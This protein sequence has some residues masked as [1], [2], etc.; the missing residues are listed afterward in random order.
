MGKTMNILQLISKNT[1]IY[2][3]SW[4]V[5]AIQELSTPDDVRSAE[6]SQGEYGLSLKVYLKAGGFFYL[7]VSTHSSISKSTPVNWDTFDLLFLQKGDEYI[8]RI[9]LRGEASL[10]EE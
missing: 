7:E 2:K 5:Y 4:K 6:W 9:C 3:E 8:E 1:K 10:D